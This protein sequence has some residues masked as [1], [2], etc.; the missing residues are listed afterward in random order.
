MATSMA[1]LSYR[2]SQVSVC[3][4]VFARPCNMRSQCYQPGSLGGVILL[5]VWN[6]PTCLRM[7]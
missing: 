5:W 4:N 6:A 2:L 3:R 7:W 1:L